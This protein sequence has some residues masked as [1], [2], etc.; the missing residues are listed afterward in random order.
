VSKMQPAG[1]PD[2]QE[3]YVTRRELADLMG[4]HVRTI[5]KMVQ[6]GMPSE[7][8]GRRTRR[9]QASKAVAWARDRRLP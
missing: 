9:F 5:D 2:G 8:W 3:R 7:T 6:A 4:L 1:C